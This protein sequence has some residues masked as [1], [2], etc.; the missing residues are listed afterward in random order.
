MGI[1][2]QASLRSRA[3]D[4]LPM[5]F[6]LGRRKQVVFQRRAVDEVLR[7]A[8]ER[9]DAIPVEDHDPTGGS[10]KGGRVP[11]A[12]SAQGGLAVHP[13][14]AVPP[15][16]VQKAGIRE[17][18]RPRRLIL[19]IGSGGHLGAL[20][21]QIEPLRTHVDTLTVAREDIGQGHRQV[22]PA[23]VG[24]KGLSGLRVDVIENGFREQLAR[25]RI[26]AHI[27][28]APVEE[29]RPAGHA[30]HD[31]LVYQHAAVHR[32]DRFELLE[33]P[34]TQVGR[35]GAKRQTSTPSANLRQYT[36]PSA[37]PKSTQPC[38]TVAGE[39][40]RPPAVN[41]HFGLPNRASSAC[42]VC[43]STPATSTV[44]AA[45]TGLLSL[46]PSCVVQA[47]LSSTG[48]AVGVN[49]LREASCR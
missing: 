12:R 3:A 23:N 10:L 32:P 25:D 34:Q 38:Q 44:P 40:I 22:G 9:I 20:P 39:S 14:R 28:H 35:H 49:P 13:E 17:Q 2:R 47:H 5:I 8:V 42:N 27:A 36:Y 21:L 43:C 41:C 33:G 37:E 48:T 26:Q 18:V 11:G 45:T 24:I 6:A 4:R 29:H 46:P 7:L 1:G 16:I 15:R 30:V 31:P 19:V